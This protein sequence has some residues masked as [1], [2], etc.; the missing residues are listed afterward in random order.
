[1]LNDVALAHLLS[2]QGIKPEHKPWLWIR[3]V[4][5]A[6]EVQLDRYSNVFHFRLKSETKPRVDHQIM[7]IIHDRLCEMSQKELLSY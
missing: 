6:H 4:E 7:K 3:S 2:S 1:M 5:E